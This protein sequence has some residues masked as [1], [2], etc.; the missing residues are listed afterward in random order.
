[1]TIAAL[2]V[3][4]VLSVVSAF[5]GADRASKLF[6]SVPLALLWSA[7][8]VLLVA[9]IAAS[10]FP[11][12]RPGQAATHLGVLLM[13]LGGAWG[14]AAGHFIRIRFFGGRRIREGVMVLEPGREEARILGQGADAAGAELGF[15]VRC[16]RFWLEFYP[17][18][19]ERWPL[20]VRLTDAEAPHRTTSYPLPTDTRE[21]TSVPGTDIRIAVLDY[22]G[23]EARPDGPALLV[24]T[25][26][27]TRIVEVA[28][29]SVIPLTDPNGEVRVEQ[30]HPGCAA[31][32][33]LRLEGEAP[34]TVRAERADVAVQ[35]PEAQAPGLAMMFL[36]ARTSQ[37]GHEWPGPLVRLII[38][39][40][41]AMYM[42]WL[43]PGDSATWAELSLAGMYADIEEWTAAGSPVIALRRPQS[44]RDYKSELVVLEDG[45]EVARKTIEVNSP[46]HYGGYHFY[47]ADYDAQYQ[48]YTVLQ[49]VSDSGLL[50]VYAGF[51]LLLMGTIWQMWIA[52]LR[53]LCGGTSE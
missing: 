16:E 1:M 52:P 39:R 15:A 24:S 10:G 43:A 28:P 42:Q 40:P 11:L 36:P 27:G 8:A 53:R 4:V 34:R 41:G 50:A 2:G 19:A 30:I 46:L 33:E 26:A 21:P 31:T 45:R 17:P 6:N 18:T 32:L 25:A 7:V 5:L 9:G 12:R 13:L 20:G 23:P 37:P 38:A 14:S 44:V 3:L 49:V 35:H 48:R 47:Q 51:A 29:G 22:L